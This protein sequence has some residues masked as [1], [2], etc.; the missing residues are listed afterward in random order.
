MVAQGATYGAMASTGRGTKAVYQV[1][2]HLVTE[3]ALILVNAVHTTVS[4]YI[5]DD[6]QGLPSDYED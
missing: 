2:Y 4:V 1:C 5:S 3:W 6:E